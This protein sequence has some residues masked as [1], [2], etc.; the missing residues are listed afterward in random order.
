MIRSS[1]ALLLVLSLLLFPVSAQA[2]GAAAGPAGNDAVDLAVGQALAA[3]LARQDVVRVEVTL[4]LTA[5]LGRDLDHPAAGSG[6]HPAVFDLAMMA[7]PGPMKLQEAGDFH[8]FQLAATRETLAKILGMKEVL[9]VALDDTPAEGPA[10]VKTSACPATSTRACLQTDFSV[11]ATYGGV[12]G[13]VA[14]VG[15]NSATFWAYSSDNWEVVAKVL[16]GC[17]VNGYWWLFAAAAGSSSYSV[18]P[19]IWLTGGSLHL[20]SWS[21]SNQPITEVQLFSCS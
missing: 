3:A 5:A 13:K 14:A 18:A 10:P 15:G 2:V 4:D 9:A 19:V 7:A 21:A 6:V 12:T 11:A 1:C 8:L 16:N 20:G 17:G